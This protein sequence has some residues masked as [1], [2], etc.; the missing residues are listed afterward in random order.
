VTRLSR[1]TEERVTDSYTTQQE[2]G[3]QYIASVSTSL[4]KEISR[5][6]KK[7]DKIMKCGRITN[8]VNTC[9]PNG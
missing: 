5:Q 3:M 7:L 4:F 9:L 1:E 6:T 2:I 8:V